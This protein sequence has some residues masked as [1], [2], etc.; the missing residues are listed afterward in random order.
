MVNRHNRIRYFTNICAT[1]SASLIIGSLGLLY[2]V[3][4]TIKTLDRIVDPKVI[5]NKKLSEY[6]YFNTTWNTDLDNQV[7]DLNVSEEV[8]SL[9]KN[10]RNLSWNS[11]SIMEWW[12]RKKSM[13]AWRL[14]EMIQSDNS[15]ERITA[16]ERLVSLKHLQDHDYCHLAQRSDAHTAVALA[17]CKEVDMRFFLKPLWS[18]SCT[19]KRELI[20]HMRDLLCHL[21]QAQK[22]V[23]LRYFIN[24]A[25]PNI[26]AWISLLDIEMLSL[27]GPPPLT[28]SENTI[29]PLCI[30]SLEHHSTISGN[31]Q[32]MVKY[33]VLSLLM[34]AYRFLGSSN[35]AALLMV[36]LIKIIASYPEHLNDLFVTGWVGVL[37]KWLNDEDN[38]LS[39]PAATALTNMD[40]DC[41]SKLGP[42]LYLLHPRH[43][44]ADRAE[45]DVDVVV[46]HGLLGGIH[47]TWRQRQLC[48]E[49]DTIF[50]MTTRSEEIFVKCAMSNST[51][52]DI[53]CS[54]FTLDEDDV[55]SDFEHVLNDIPVAESGELMEK[56]K[57][58]EFKLSYNGK[59]MLIKKLEKTP[60]CSTL[61]WPKDW[62]AQDCPRIRI[63]GL[64]Y[65]TKLTDWVSWCPL[66]DKREKNKLRSKSEDF[67]QQLIAGGIG[68][69]PIVW[70]SHSMGGILV[71]HMI[72]QAWKKR[73]LNKAYYN[74]LS[75]TNSI[76]FLS[77]PHYGSPLATLNE[78]YKLLFLPSREVE[79]LSFNSPTLIKLHTEFLEFLREHP[80]KVLSFNETKCMKIT[81]L[82][83]EVRCVPRGLGDIGSGL[84]YEIPLGHMDI[85][86]PNCRFSFIYQTILQMIRS[87]AE[88]KIKN[89]A[90]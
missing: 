90:T 53:P 63:I 14:L 18:K 61:C 73:D 44:P 45:A 26:S 4:A 25:F 67:L 48:S 38:R 12:Q 10:R 51:I 13:M 35:D 9:S 16:A 87:A 3:Y 74:F 15:N 85:C 50:G 84:I 49:A 72:V 46:V 89:K 40:R 43:R 31:A 8:E 71:K 65:D 47:Y 70:I 57:D 56:F 66:M 86:K 69:R 21:N 17:R 80:T 62:L 78:A 22:H 68:E 55:G 33:G 20:S 37:A 5:R 77:T 23:C 59:D 29:L 75:N 81:P 79:E 64:N 27:E 30:Q 7:M 39:V 28:I 36:K 32:I 19:D 42:N 60:S 52:G 82:E 88:H 2:G 11:I 83:L 24:K 54:L 6:I 34:D 76:V 41:R 58:E 1:V